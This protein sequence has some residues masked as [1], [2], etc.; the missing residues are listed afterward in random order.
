[1]NKSNFRGSPV[2]VFPGFFVETKPLRA[3]RYVIITAHLTISHRNYVYLS[4]TEVII[5]HEEGKL[6]RVYNM[7]PRCGINS[8]SIEWFSDKYVILSI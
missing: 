5:C 8:I 2:G 7:K 6:T 1:M 4:H 3:I